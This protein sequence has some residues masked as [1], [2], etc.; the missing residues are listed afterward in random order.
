MKYKLMLICICIISIVNVNAQSNTVGPGIALDID[1]A[2]G[3]YINL[4]DV[5]NTLNFPVSFEAWVYPTNFEDPYSGIFATDSKSIGNY[6]GMHIRFYTSGALA[7]EIGDGTGAG[8]SDRRGKKTTTFVSLNTWTH[9]VVVATSATDIQVYF[10]GV[11]QPSVNT[12]GSSGATNM[13]HNSNPAEIG[14]YAT[15]FDTHNFYGQLD[16]VR[17]WNISRTETDIRN[18]MCHKLTGIESGLVGYWNVDESYLSTTVNDLTTPAENGTITGTVD[19]ITSSVPIGDVSTNQ[20][21]VDWSGVTL[22][23]NSPGGDKLKINKI[24]NSPVGVHLYRV[25]SGPYYFDGLTGYT[26]Y[27]YGVFTINGAIG[28]KYTAAY[29]Y[30]LSNG[31]TTVDNEINSKLS[32]RNN[33]S[34]LSWS[35]AGATLNTTGNKLTK[36]NVTSMK[37]FIYNN[38]IPGGAKYEGELAINAIRIYPNPATDF[39]DISNC[40][41]NDQIK[42]V[43]L[44]GKEI[45]IQAEINGNVCHISL[46]NVPKG[47]YFVYSTGFSK[48][49]GK[50]IVQ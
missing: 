35:D 5:Y 15:V 22:S 26:N 40:T 31:V 24:L 30:S 38:V 41:A 2:T 20:Y 48:C 3:N 47:I 28:A 6:Y 1:G 16:D 7:F 49:L 42:L 50:V 13:V 27:Y 39:I 45:N 25:N 36:K 33:A 14:R 29:I 21:V 18:N 9:L 23:L 37:E 12:D 17:L 32:I 34:V 4:G 44:S 43:D 19:K 8:V 11:L 46:T 10:N